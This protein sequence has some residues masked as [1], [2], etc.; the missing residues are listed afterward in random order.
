MFMFDVVAL[1]ES[2]I[3]FTPCGLNAAGM[4]MFSRNPGG[5][6]ANVLAMNAKLRGKTAFIGM[7]GKNDFGLFLRKTMEESGINCDGLRYSDDVP[8]TIAFVQLN[9]HGDRSFTFYRK[10]GADIMLT[11]NDVDKR[12]LETCHIFHFGSVSLTDEPCR[13]ETFEAA[14]H[15]RAHGALISYDP[16]YRPL[17]WR[18]EEEAALEMKRPLGMTDIL[19]VSKEEMVLLTGETSLE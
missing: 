11:W 2:L 8:T 10:L 13:S 1:G 15:A 3:D 5:A 16:N 17:L 14:K 19:K 12:M 4:L 18:S 7:V 6:P 9:E